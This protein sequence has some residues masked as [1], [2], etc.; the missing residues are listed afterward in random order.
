MILLRSEKNRILDNLE[1]I[2]KN[3]IKINLLCHIAKNDWKGKSKK[4]KIN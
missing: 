4:K 2:L 1:F 3:N